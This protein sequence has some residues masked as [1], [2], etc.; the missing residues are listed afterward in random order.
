MFSNG[1]ITH[2]FGNGKASIK[3]Q[4]DKGWLNRMSLVSTSVKRPKKFKS[5]MGGTGWPDNIGRVHDQYNGQ[6]SAESWG[7]KESLRLPLAQVVSSLLSS[8][9]LN[10]TI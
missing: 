6:V 3:A 2:V 8:L 1:T 7:S 4:N 5:K 10:S 9:S